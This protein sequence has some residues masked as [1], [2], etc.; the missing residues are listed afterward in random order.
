[1]NK[2]R[3]KEIA[4]SPIMANVTYNGVPIYIESVNEDNGI[5]YI[6]SLDNPE[7]RQQVSITNLEEH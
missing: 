7:N 2:R 6:H 5:A 4:S 3:A 1:M